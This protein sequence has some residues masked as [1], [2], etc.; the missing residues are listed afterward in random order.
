[1]YRLMLPL[2]PSNADHSLSNS[3]HSQFLHKIVHEKH[4]KL[5]EEDHALRVQKK[6]IETEAA[7][8]H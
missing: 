8:Y 3:C 5:Y 7:M 6:E 1:M 4:A 2:Q